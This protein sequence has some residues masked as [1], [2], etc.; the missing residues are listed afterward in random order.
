MKYTDR[1]SAN[2]RIIAHYDDELKAYKKLTDDI[3]N[4]VKLFLGSHLCH[5]RDILNEI[6]LKIETFK[7]EHPEYSDENPVEFNDEE[8]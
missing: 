2:N 4:F 1:I 3:E 5:N 8:S 7:E 6:L